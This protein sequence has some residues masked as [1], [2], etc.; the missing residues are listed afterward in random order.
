MRPVRR[1]SHA[2]SGHD[3]RQKRRFRYNRS[4]LDGK[5]ADTR[6]TAKLSES[7]CG[8]DVCPRYITLLHSGMPNWVL[9]RYRPERP[10]GGFGGKW[11]PRSPLWPAGR[12]PPARPSHFSC[13]S[14]PWHACMLHQSEFKAAVVVVELWWGGRPAAAVVLAPAASC[15]REVNGSTIYLLSSFRG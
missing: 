8:E 14:T 11:W 10:R 5:H 7:A 6:L 13:C 15:Q 9:Y 4:L 12:P 1:P 2:P 3:G